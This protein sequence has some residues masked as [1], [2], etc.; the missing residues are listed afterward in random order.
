MIDA[1]A[2]VDVI[3]SHNDTP[4]T[5]VANLPRQPQAVAIATVLVANGAPL[6]AGS[7]TPL[8]VAISR[9]SLE[10][11]ELMLRSPGVPQREKDLA[12][13]QALHDKEGAI[14]VALINAGATPD[15]TP[16]AGAYAQ[17]ASALYEAVFPKLNRELVK[18]L[19]ARK[20]SPN[21]VGRDGST[22]LIHVI[23]DFEL[24]L[25][26]LDAGAD[27]D[28]RQTSDGRTAL[29]VAVT[30]PDVKTR[31]DVVELLLRRK[32][33]PN[34]PDAS[35]Y[36]ALMYVPSTD[37]RV[38]EAIVNA[39]GKV[40]VAG[41]D[42][43][44]YR[45]YNV[46]VGPVTWAIVHGKDELGAML[47]LRDK[48]VADEDCGAIYYAA[49]SGSIATLRGLFNVNAN[50][51]AASGTN[52]MTPFLFT[53]LR[54]QVEAMSVLLER[55][56]GNVNEVMPVGRE[57]ALM[58]AAAQ[59]HVATITFL[60]DRGADVNARASSNL[61]ALGYAKAGRSEET[62][63]LLLQHGAVD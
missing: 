50:P 49:G 12:L 56:A 10:M 26:L 35:G 45:Q 39:G 60:I 16:P 21:V 61:T 38:M 42:A 11:V 6:G 55:K 8:Y 32:A 44:Y 20:V 3:D 23:G 58:L 17:D 59:G 41:T 30:L 5:I 53:A 2:R 13:R 51:R 7:P 52:G 33:N 25:L 14:A 62:I 29:H 43:A 1:G 18:A 37:L 57:T 36:T 46:P 48:R 15:A 31:S 9:G 54:G 40:L 27:P 34:I 28:V 4:L 24:A 63:R 47:L 19:I 22:P